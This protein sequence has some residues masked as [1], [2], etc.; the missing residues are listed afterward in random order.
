MKTDAVMMKTLS[1]QFA[2]KRLLFLLLLFHA[3]CHYNYCVNNLDSS[4]TPLCQ[5]VLT[6]TQTAG[7][8]K[9]LDSNLRPNI[10]LKRWCVTCGWGE[11][12]HLGGKLNNNC[13]EREA[14]CHIFLLL[15]ISVGN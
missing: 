6:F 14:Y 10:T 11:V 12:I 15:I 13:T 9:Q 7:F 2:A 8:A 4:N 5:L 1:S 3:H